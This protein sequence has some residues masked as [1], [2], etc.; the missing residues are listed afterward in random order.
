MLHKHYPDKWKEFKDDWP[1]KFAT[2]RIEPEIHVDIA[3]IGMSSKPFGA[4]IEESS[5]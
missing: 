2:L 5:E 1:E 3:R 4:Q